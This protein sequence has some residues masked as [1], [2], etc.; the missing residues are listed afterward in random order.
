MS[1]E[2]FERVS[3]EF[4]RRGFSLMPDSVDPTWSGVLH[5]PNPLP[6]TVSLPTDFPFALPVIVIDRSRLARRV[7]HVEWTGKV[8]IAPNTSLLLDDQRP[9]VIVTEALDRATKVIERGLVGDND[10]DFGV[11]ILAYWV[12]ASDTTAYYIGSA[13]DAVGSLDVGTFVNRGGDTARGTIV[14][15]ARADVDLFCTRVNCAI[16][17]R[18]A[19]IYVPITRALD[20]PTPGTR[21][22]VGDVWSALR[23]RVDAENTRLLNAELEKKQAPFLMVLG[24][25][26]STVRGRALV[27][28]NF[29][30]LPGRGRHAGGR[31]RALRRKQIIACT[32]KEDAKLVTIERLAQQHLLARA[33]A[34]SS[35]QGMRVALVGCGAVGGYLAHTLCALG[36]QSLVLVDADM[37]MPENLYRHYLGFQYLKRLKAD[38]LRECLRRSFLHVAID[39]RPVRVQDLWRNEPALLRDVD[40][41]VFATGDESTERQM[42]RE[43]HPYTRAVHAW[44]EPQGIG[45]HV[46]VSSAVDQRGCYGCLFGVDENGVLYNRASFARAGQEYLQTMAGCSGAFS[47][48]SSLDAERAALECVR[49]VRDLVCAGKTEA[50]VVSWLESK[51]GFR[52]AGLVLSELGEDMHEGERRV[53]PIPSGCTMC[54]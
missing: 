17:Q 53:R 49:A 15:D 4:A 40:A 14:G 7:P 10:A 44:V 20:A 45:G 51:S 52:D 50:A 26:S 19:G 25:A 42:A 23:Q 29:P 13:A 5:V 35:L 48:F 46:F 43:L 28:V 31:P 38:A 22:R 54:S 39:S 2:A 9:E 36:V 6:C 34:S 32:R 16:T 3:S 1:P 8:C 27:G 41:V 24:Q 37:L 30:A 33:G 12:E 11:E 21:H 18:H 47:P